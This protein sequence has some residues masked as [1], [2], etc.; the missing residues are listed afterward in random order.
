MARTAY[1]QATERFPV[2]AVTTAL[3]APH[4][5]AIVVSPPAV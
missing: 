3:Q 2:T 1:T 5:Q 4:S